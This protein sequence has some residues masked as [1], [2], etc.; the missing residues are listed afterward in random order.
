MAT[1]RKY[2]RDHLVL[3]LLSIDAFLTLLATSLILLRLSSSHSNGY[4]V[5]CRDCSDLT[6]RKFTSGSLSELLALILFAFIVLLIHGFLSMR[7]YHIHR[8]L[9]VTILG[10]ATVLLALTVLVGNFLLGLR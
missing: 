3:L 2:F 5:Q 9:S 10:L 6:I 8:Q 7:T 1:S 4:I